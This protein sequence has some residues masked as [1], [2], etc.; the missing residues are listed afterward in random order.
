MNI[1]DIYNKIFPL[2]N[3]DDNNRYI[4]LTGDKINSVQLIEPTISVSPLV[5]TNKEH[6]DKYNYPEKLAFRTPV[7]SI[8]GY[9]LNQLDITYFTLDYNSFI[10]TCTVEFVDSSNDL[11]STNTLKDGSIIKIYIGGN[12]DEN[13][14]KPI[15]QDF[16]VT[17][18]KKIDG[19]QQNTGGLMK[20]KVYGTL[21]VPFGYRKGSWSYNKSTALQ[22]VFNLAVYTGLGF[23]T[24]FTNPNSL[25]EMN[26]VNNE[27]STYFDFIQNV[28]EHACYSPNTFFTSFVDQF[29]VLNF[30]E[31]HS[32]LSHGGKKTDTPAIIYSNIGDDYSN[33]YTGNN[34]NISYKASTEEVVNN[35]SQKVSY[36]F[37]SN[38]EIYSG[39]SNFIEEYTEIN[40]G[41]SSISDGYIK[42]I[43]YSD[44]NT[45]NWGTK[46]CEFIIRPIDNLTREYSTQDI[47]NLPDEATQDSYIPLNLMKTTSPDYNEND[48][49]SVDDLSSVESFTSYGEVDTTNTFKQYYFAEAQNKYQMKCLKK[50]GLRVILQNYN[51]SITKFSRIWVDIYDK[52]ML[53]SEQI[54]GYT[55]LRN[56][57]KEIQNYKDAFNDNIL[58][59]DDEGINDVNDNNKNSPRGEYN[60]ALSGWY[61]V[62][63]MELY[64]ISR[65]SN[66]KMKLTLNRIEYQPM[67][68]HEYN[69]A[70]DAIVKYKEDNKIENIFINKDDYSNYL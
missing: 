29:N 4:N 37:I 25:D 17:S 12:G 30:V 14:Y 43:S 56:D 7:I 69:I 53:S 33:E 39:W 41:Y 58:K 28:T 1:N 54:K 62:T 18:V 48:Y 19:T 6:Q 8:N 34:K 55:K 26:W 15:R 57:S 22:T 46:N 59:F 40:N 31:C 44:S 35:G 66:I 38:N 16:L 2:G 47:S 9:K 63:E 23:A 67:F 36:Y 52:N 5:I 68:K 27:N 42:H 13:Y 51:P 10:P 60:R 11:L 49:A 20:Y 45:G 50:C 70:K 32:L 65:E 61:V 21:F 64:Y 3:I 24:N